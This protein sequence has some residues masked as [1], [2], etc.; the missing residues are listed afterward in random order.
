MHLFRRLAKPKPEAPCLLR[1]GPSMDALIPVDDPE[2]TGAYQLAIDDLIREQAPERI[3]LVS[4]TPAD[5]SLVRKAIRYLA[6]LGGE[7]PVAPQLSD[8]DV[9]GILEVEVDFYR[10]CRDDPEGD[11]G[12]F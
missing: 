4:D 11:S 8:A 7:V 10:A 3:Y 1:I 2:G 6:E 9:A 5:L 12:S